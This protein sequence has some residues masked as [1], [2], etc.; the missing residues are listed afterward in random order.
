MKQRIEKIK[1]HVRENKETYINGVI[2]LI[3][4]TAASYIAF[5]SDDETISVNGTIN[6]DNNTL[7]QTV[8][9][10]KRGHPGNVILCN[11]TG[12]KFA[13]QNRAAAAMGLNPSEVSKQVRGLIPDVKGYTFTNLGEAQ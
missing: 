4:V 12:E 1:N 11:E 3:T 5:H 6:G 7:V 2:C 10:V 13:S 9:L 8:T